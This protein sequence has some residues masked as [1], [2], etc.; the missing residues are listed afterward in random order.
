MEY[1][2]NIT[3][4]TTV[5]LLIVLIMKTLLKNRISPK[6]HFVLWGI[7]AVRLLIPVLPESDLSIFNRVPQVQYIHEENIDEMD[8]FRS[9][10]IY[11]EQINE[12]EDTVTINVNN[13]DKEFSI[14]K[15]L[16]DNIFNIWLAGSISLLLYIISVYII[17]N[18][19]TKKY[20]ILKNTEALS[21]F[22]E[23]KKQLGITTHVTVREGGET[24]LLKG[25]V[26]PKI[27]IPKNYTKDELKSVFMHELIHLKHRDIL[28][29][30]V[31]ALLLCVYWYNPIVWYSFFI[32]KRDME[33]L[34]DYRVLESYKDRKAY[35]AVLLKTALKKN[36]FIFGTTS[37]QNGK[38]DISKRIKYIA[39]FKK[40]KIIWSIIT[41]ILVVVVMT[42][43][44]TNPTGKENNEIVGLD[45]K[46]IY[47]N[48]T[49]Y[50]GNASKVGNLTSNIYYADYKTGISLKTDN[51]PFEITVNYTV[52]LESEGLID[53]NEVKLTDKMLKN[54]AIIFCLIDNVDK[55][56]F[57]LHDDGEVYALP[58]E[59]QLLEEIFKEDIRSYSSSYDKF[60]NEFIP[61]LERE[62]WNDVDLEVYITNTV[63]IYVW[64]NKDITGTDDIYYTIFPGTNFIKSKEEIYDLEI[65]KKDLS[66]VNNYLS[67][68]YESPHLSIKHDSS[69]SKE[70]M[71]NLDKYII[72]ETSHSRS[73]GVF[74]DLLDKD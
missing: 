17:H 51:E 58:F 53:N 30:I 29:N 5:T 36:Q 1:F 65:A 48:K 73:I 64:R 74:G 11:N 49:L 43:C 22:E 38:K 34:C 10:T 63:E 39:Y 27:I 60:R 18:L 12:I 59:R 71:I 56:N 72:I 23:C 68:Y 13:I 24:P 20:N 45:Y 41:A 70:E 50:V 47:E 4:T 67:Q 9:N 33:I 2:I 21:V 55:V 15:N 54:A 57:A 19:K 37:M 6:W 28:W 35:A 66:E 52:D 42:G 69:F 31:G 16:E 25:F 62:N 8:S 3:I 14:S 46:K 40:P 44:L 26:H 7:I 61:L 32:F